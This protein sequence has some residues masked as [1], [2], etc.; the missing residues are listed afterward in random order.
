MKSF[1]TKSAQILFVLFILSVG[2]SAFASYYASGSGYNAG[3]HP[4]RVIY[5]PQPQQIQY[6]PVQQP[7]VIYQQPIQYQ[8]TTP[9]VSTSAPSSVGATAATLSGYVSGNGY[10]VNSWIEFP[11]YSSSQY[12]TQYNISNV[13][14]SP[15]VYNLFPNTS[16]SYCAVAQN[17]SNNQIVR[18]NSVSFITA[19]N[20]VTTITTPVFT[21]VT[22][23]ASGVD[24]S[25]V[26]LN[27]SINNPFIYSSVSEYFEY[28]TTIYM[29][30]QTTP[31]VLGSQNY[32]D[33][34]ESVSGLSENTNYYYRTV[35][36]NPGVTTKGSIQVFTTLG[37]P[38]IAP[39]SNTTNIK[40][41][42]APATQVPT[43]NPNVNQAPLSASA[44]FGSSLIP[45]DANTWLILILIVITLVLVVRTFY[46]QGHRNGY[47]HHMNQSM[48]QISTPVVHNDE[49]KNTH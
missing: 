27:G 5:L 40:N 48:A 16:Y 46:I 8:N 30:S 4:N 25:S 18:G 12:G 26:V 36:V 20:P 19:P 2:N 13:D 11:C 15:T 1:I 41:Q 33:F 38:Q 6:I 17:P 7:Q 45:V 35:A 37:N 23:S 14:L 22:K 32:I 31:R 9:S 29:G 21:A 24:R 44:I 47:D 42:Q 28:G 34:S 43:V 10:L 39:A 3:F 49:T